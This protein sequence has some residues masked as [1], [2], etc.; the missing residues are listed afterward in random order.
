MVYS[1]H[2]DGTNNQ[3]PQTDKTRGN[4]DTS[5]DFDDAFAAAAGLAIAKQLKDDP[6]ARSVLYFID[7]GEEGWYNVGTRPLG[8]SSCR[9]LWTASGITLSM[10]RRVEFRVKRRLHVGSDWIVIL[11]RQWRQEHFA[12]CF[13][14]Y[15]S[16]SMHLAPFAIRVMNPTVDLAKIK[17]VYVID[18]LGSPFNAAN[19][20]LVAFGVD[21]ATFNG[22]NATIRRPS[23]LTFSTQI[24]HKAKSI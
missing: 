3:N 13:A 17:M 15:H 2:T 8:Q 23:R 1:A 9:P 18:P 5:D 6:P 21:Q 20:V 22:T 19:N 11:V 10:K 12:V 7:D 4:T 24:I 14:E 16:H